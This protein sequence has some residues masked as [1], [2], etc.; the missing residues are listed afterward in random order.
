MK[1]PSATY[2]I[3]FT[4]DFGF[5]EALGI[6]GYLAE[7]GG[8]WVYASPIF[9]ARPGSLHGYDAV[10]PNRLN[11]ELG[12]EAD[13]DELLAALRQREMGWLQDVVP[14]HLAYSGENPMV[15]DLFALGENSAFADFFD[16]TWDHPSEQLSGKV[17]APFLGDR[18]T[19]C[20]ERGEI[21]LDLRKGILG[22]AYYEHF[23][24]LRLFSYGIL[25]P[26]IPG[27]G[28][29]IFEDAG[30]DFLNAVRKLVLNAAEP[31][32]P[33]RDGF[34]LEQ[35]LAIRRLVDRHRQVRRFI[36][37]RLQSFDPKK[38]GP[39]AAASLK[40][41]LSDQVFRL[42]H[43][44][45]A[46]KEINYRRF[47]D[48]NELICLRQEASSIFHHT[49]RLLRRLTGEEK[50]D[51]VRIDHIDGLR[52]P[53]GYLRR[54]RQAC[55]DVYIAVE[56]IL[57]PEEPLPPSWPVQ[58]ATGYE[59]ADKVTRLFCPGDRQEQISAVYRDFS[60]RKEPFDEVC[61]TAKKQ[62]LKEAFA[63]DLANL[64]DRFRA[65]G[66][67]AGEK[68]SLAPD[69]LSA[70]VAELLA[71]FPVYRT[72]AGEAGATGDDADLIRE[73]IEEASAQVP[74]LGQAL[75]VVCG[76]LLAEDET[77]SL[78]GISGFARG[79]A[80]ARFQ[81]L[82]APLAAKGVEDTALYRYHRLC[83]L[84]E[85][86]GDPS[87][88]GISLSSFYAFLFD[89]SENFPH[90]I[91]ALSTHDTKRSEDVRAR[92]NV[93]SE[94]PEDWR[95]RCETW[96]EMNR[97]KKELSNGAAVPGANTEY[98]LYQTL[99]GTFP[100]EP[101][102]LEQ[103]GERIGNYMVKAVRE[104]K[105]HS[106]WLSPDT[107]YEEALCR[108]IDR[109]LM[110]PEKDDPFMAD[111]LS[112]A[113]KISRFGVY[114]SLSQSLIKITAPGIPDF[115]QGT[116]L[117]DFSLVDPDN[118][119]AVDFTRRKKLLEEIRSRQLPGPPAR[120]DGRRKKEDYDRMKLYLVFAGLQVRKQ[121]PALFGTGRF[122]PLYADGRF[123]DHVVAFAR[124]HGS[125][126]SL[127]AVP[128]WL[129]TVAPDGREPIGE[130][131]EDTALTLSDGFP[132][133]WTNAVSGERYNFGE[134]LPLEE[135]FGQ[136]P[137]ALLTAE[138][139]S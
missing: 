96:K 94:I 13:F 133:T 63:G 125:Q 129:T 57:G 85:V 138:V 98:L 19:D 128:R 43:W 115:Y 124:I 54:L 53:A 134:T 76:I 109:L 118:R 46:T 110:T 55:G 69:I 56:K 38:G 1:T 135:I 82:C 11:P 28:D 104:A 105:E 20:L 39:E 35:K 70:A 102:D 84:N 18:L 52:D 21:R 74:A 91:N 130:V 31:P 137:A 132:T 123:A 45:T 64:V 26:E 27:A 44:R 15:A 40:R 88:T 14:N 10:N 58:G 6:V 33:D 101:K 24:P 37:R 66:E 49:H 16:I 117:F 122:L 41:L 136:F 65:A 92:I 29:R 120:P 121:R 25:D 99:V 2:R 80:A 5:R 83:S 60:G 114:N 71:R 42:R 36:D 79:E 75:G 72:Y 68:A 7:L 50:I 77:G 81:Q 48:I 100:F 139:E 8:F 17:S 107:G 30:T 61:R 62:V 87:R 108:F 23:F 22:A 34:I 127:T 9:E 90:A 93:L 116:E 3:Q 86:G 111:F 113:K 95:L 51:G 47:F 89:R 103:Y 4:P 97:T 59:F 73:I 112:F 131:W 32:S 67:E 12:S 119:R 126:Y 106:S 78:P